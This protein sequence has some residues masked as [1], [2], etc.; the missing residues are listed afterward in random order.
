MLAS[1]AAV[2]PAATGA[3]APVVVE[4]EEEVDATNVVVVDEVVP[5][6]SNSFLVRPYSLW[7]IE[8]FHCTFTATQF[9]R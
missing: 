9:A 4:V 3:T 8:S 6:P 2:V 5:Q 1:S 7:S